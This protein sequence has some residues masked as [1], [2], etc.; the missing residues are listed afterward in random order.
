LFLSGKNP[1]TSEGFLVWLDTA[2]AGFLKE[3]GIIHGAIVLGKYIITPTQRVYSFISKIAKT[4]GYL[5][6]CLI[7]LACSKFPGLLVSCILTGLLE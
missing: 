1:G 2:F 3:K 4:I 7:L 6:P 5:L